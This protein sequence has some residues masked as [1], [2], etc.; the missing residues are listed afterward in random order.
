VHTRDNSL[1]LFEFKFRKAIGAEVIKEMK[2]KVS[3]LKYPR[4]L[5]IITVLVYEG[6]LAEKVRNEEYFDYIYSGS[7]LLEF[8]P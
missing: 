8:K 3:V 2:Q 6:E 5:S 7:D 1:Y 4:Y